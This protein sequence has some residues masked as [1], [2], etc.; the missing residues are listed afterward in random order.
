M[1]DVWFLI[2]CVL[3][4]GYV[5]LDGFDFG[6][7]A[8]H[9]FVARDDAERRQ[10]I[11]AIGPFWDGNEVFLLAA[12]GALFAAFSKVLASALSGLYLAVILVLWTILL[13]GIS[14]ELRSH[15]RDA[16]WRA[17]WDRVFQLSSALL[18]LLFGVALGAV[19]RGFPLQDDG[20][21]A[22][23]LFSLESPSRGLGVIDGYTLVTG[24]LALLLLAQHGGRFLAMRASG[25]VAER[26]SRI[27]QALTLPVVGAWLCASVLSWLFAH[28]AVLAFAARP[29][30]WPLGLLAVAAQA[31][32]WRFARAGA[33]GRA[34]LASCAVV[35]SL[36]GIA[37]VSLHPVFLRS[38]TS[39]PSLT[40]YNAAN[41]DSALAL[42]LRWWVFSFALVVAYFVNLFRVHRG[43]VTPYGEGGD[44][45]ETDAS[46][47]G[48][49]AHGA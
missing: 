22:L 7:G 36:L 12:G 31:L 19:L 47:E 46:G 1:A 15:L 27:A 32:G 29:W 48:D 14:L 37:V 41:P 8:L 4:L 26:A 44:E 17:F 25:Q 28:D 43:P 49:D 23:E 13:R 45:D 21:F 38:T 18:A 30:A 10:V 34:F 5:V 6:A 9:R 40:A 42:G 2:V 16:M 35:G 20:Y 33:N 39:A 11:A 3:L 24:V